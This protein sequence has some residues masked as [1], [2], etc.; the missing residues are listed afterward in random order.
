MDK[1]SD[2]D[3][4]KRPQD[5]DA[6]DEYYYSMIQPD[7]E[8]TFNFEQRQE[9]RG[10][11]KRIARVPSQKIIDVR[12]TFWFIKRLYLVLFIGID[13]RRREP[14]GIWH[15]LLAVFIRVLVF[16]ILSVLLALVI[17]GVM[18]IGKSEMGIDIFPDRHLS[19]VLH[20]NRSE[21]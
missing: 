14:V 20:L 19:D 11:F 7:V 15:E 4:D 10:V 3:R 13:R 5:R 21:E 1:F 17:L 9:L 2:N 18:Y 12:T 6:G 8:K 16:L